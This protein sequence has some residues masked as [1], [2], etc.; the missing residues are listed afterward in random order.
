MIVD[1]LKPPVQPTIDAASAA[2][3]RAL[4][5]LNTLDGSNPREHLEAQL[6]ATEAHAAYLR[7]LLAVQ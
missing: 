4:R 7:A 3:V 1:Q 2:W 5:R 6:D